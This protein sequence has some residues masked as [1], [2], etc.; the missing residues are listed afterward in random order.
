VTQKWKKW[1]NEDFKVIPLNGAMNKWRE[2]EASKRTFHHREWLVPKW[3]KAI[4][5]T[6]SASSL[7][8]FYWWNQINASNITVDQIKK[9]RFLVF[10]FVSRLVLLIENRKSC[11]F[12]NVVCLCGKSIERKWIRI[13]SGFSFPT[14]NIGFFFLTQ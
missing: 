11:F 2:V 7:I 13:I 3:D 9:P 10:F 4:K 5:S 1:K 6:L 14:C 12:F 8:F